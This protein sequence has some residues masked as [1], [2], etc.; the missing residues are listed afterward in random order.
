MGYVIKKGSGG[1]GGDATAANQLTQID[2]QIDSNDI[3]TI[4]KDN[5]L[6]VN[7]ANGF[8]YKRNYF[9]EA[10]QINCWNSMIV[11]LNASGNPNEFY[12]SHTLYFNS[13]DNE[14]ILTLISAIY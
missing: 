9:I 12:V 13:D 10:N 3:A 6:R 1:G 7:A 2:L 14:F 4:N 11:Y 5:N 8:T